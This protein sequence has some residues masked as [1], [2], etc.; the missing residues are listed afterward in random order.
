M[1]LTRITVLSLLALIGQGCGEI[2]TTGSVEALT[3]QLH[4]DRHEL[5]E[6]AKG[7]PFNEPGSLEEAQADLNKIKSLMDSGSEQ[8]SESQVLAIPVLEEYIEAIKTG[9]RELR[10]LRNRIEDTEQ[11]LQKLTGAI[12]NSAPNKETM[13]IRSRDELDDPLN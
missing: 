13:P 10:D 8:V 9:R 5:M 2:E 4:T 7:I 12:P 1:K 6:I 11:K 3:R